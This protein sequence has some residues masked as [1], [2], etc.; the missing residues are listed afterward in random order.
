MKRL[1][2]DLNRQKNTAAG[3]AVVADTYWQARKAADAMVVSWDGAI[4]RED[5]SA[6]MRQRMIQNIETAE[7]KGKV[8]GGDLAAAFASADR[9]VEATYYHPHWAHTNMEPHNCVA[10]VKD[11]SAEIWVGHQS[12]TESLNAVKIATGLPIHKIKSNV[13]RCGTGLGRK[14]VHDFV[15]EACILSKTVKAPVKVTWSREDEMEQD[16]LNSAG[17]Y[18]IRAAL[19]KK[20]D[21]TG[22]HLRSATDDWWQ[23]AA[24]E[25]PSGLVENYLGEWGYIDSNVRQGAW[26]GPQHNTAAWVTQGFLNELA[27]EAG[28]DPLEYL[29]AFYSRRETLKLNTWPFPLLEFSRFKDLLKQVAKEAKY[30]RK[31]PKGWGQGIAVYHTFASTCAHVVEVEMLGEHDYRVHKVTAAI[32]CGLAVNPL[33]IRAQVEGGIND[34]LCAA[35]YGEFLFDHGVPVTN[36]F[37][38][39]QKMRIAEAPP[40]INVTIVDFGDE[41]PR[42]TGEVALPPLI[43]A[44]TN[45]IFAASGK[46]IRTLPIS[47]NL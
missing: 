4:S 7:P 29:L 12:L 43:P 19:D 20:G 3:V 38:T 33:G 34:G 16:Y 23:N 18:K 17:T 42:G 31:M 30:G 1:P 14:Y 45:A 21:L 8:E 15:T 22:W 44:L 24:K 40:E 10:D 37:D 36:N 39:Y 5:D 47:K 35:K 41:L 27:H 32:D 28:R 26:R 25:P 13:Y 11:E 2:E 9:V 46:R 6:L